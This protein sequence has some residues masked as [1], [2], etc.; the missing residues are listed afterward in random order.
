MSDIVGYRFRSGG[1]GAI[2]LCTHYLKSCGFMMK[3]IKIE[4]PKSE[5][6]DFYNR[7][8]GDVICISERAPGRTFHRVDW[9]EEE[10][11]HETNCECHECSICT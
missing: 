4:T 10:V 3:L 1:A 9:D 8:I 6:V 11:A 7:K 5:G 2:Y